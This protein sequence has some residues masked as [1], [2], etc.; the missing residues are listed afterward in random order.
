LNIANGVLGA[1]DTV[2]GGTGDDIIRVT[3]TSI[4]LVDADFTSV[5][6]MEVLESSTNNTA[7]TVTLAAQAQSA[8][9]DTV[10][11]GTSADNINLSAYTI[12]TTISGGD[13]ADTITGSA[14]TD[15]I[16][17]GAGNDTITITE[18]TGVNAVDAITFAS[19]ATNGIDTIA[20]FE[21]GSDTLTLLNADTSAPTATGAAAVTVVNSAS[22]LALAATFRLDLLSDTNVD[23]VVELLGLNSDNGDLG[24]AGVTDGTELLKLMGVTGSAAAS[25]TTDANGEK[26]YVAAYDNGNAYLYLVEPGADAVATAAEITPVGVLTGIAVG[27]LQAADFVMG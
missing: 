11:G 2:A 13:G 9:I 14:G 10:N 21:T 25:I 8:G 5:S 23:D 24:K 4:T 3:G 7:M 19:A 26:L 16:Q 6:S 15:A 20:G 22:S 18:A 27:G 17:G 1:S 12:A